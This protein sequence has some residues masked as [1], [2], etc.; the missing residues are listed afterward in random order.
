MT[1]A[2]EN[3]W[4]DCAAEAVESM[5]TKALYDGKI[6]GTKAIANTLRSIVVMSHQNDPCSW[7]VEPD[8]IGELVNAVANMAF[9]VA[10][11]HSS[12]ERVYRAVESLRDKPG[13]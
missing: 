3:D 12:I 10:P 7:D 8:R 5:L 1:S 2:K 4:A 11:T 6:I 13:S 9:Y